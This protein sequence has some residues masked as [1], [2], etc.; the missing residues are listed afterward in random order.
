MELRWKLAYES[1]V[2]VKMTAKTANPLQV[3]VVVQHSARVTSLL[4]TASLFNS[5]A[6]S[7]RDWVFIGVGVVCCVLCD[8]YSSCCV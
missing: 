1:G 6:D 8:M 3:S 7:I 2:E 5:S 4:Q